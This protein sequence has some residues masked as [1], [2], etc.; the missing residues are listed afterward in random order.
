MDETISGSC[1]MAGCGISGVESSCQCQ[2]SYKVCGLSTPEKG[3]AVPTPADRLTRLASQRHTAIS[4]S[5]LNSCKAVP[6]QRSPAC[7]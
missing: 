7:F 5:L 3:A 6:G 4:D 2:V 1:Q